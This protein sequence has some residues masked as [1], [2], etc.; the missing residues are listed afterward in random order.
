[1]EFLEQFVP[2]ATIVVVCVFV[3]IWLK[4]AFKDDEKRLADIPWILGLVGAALGVVGTFVLADL[5]GLDVLTAVAQ[6][7]VSGL[8]AGGAYQVVHQQDKIRNL[9][10]DWED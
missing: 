4:Q 3:G 10:S 5:Q 9:D 6:G 2:N 7:I 1:M 8:A